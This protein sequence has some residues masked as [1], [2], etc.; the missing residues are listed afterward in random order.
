MGSSGIISLA[1]RNDGGGE[2]EGGEL[3]GLALLTGDEGLDDIDNL[4]LL[5]ARQTADGL[6][7]AA[8][9]SA[10]REPLLGSGLAEQFL[11]GDAEGLGHRGQDIGA[12]RFTRVLPILD[13]GLAVAYLAGQLTLRK[14]GGLTEG[15]ESRRTICHEA[16]VRGEMEN[17]LHVTSLLVIHEQCKSS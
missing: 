13:I 10:R 14:P 6:D 5:A 1:P 17:G 4:V 7:D 11:N 15:A 8:E 2:K 12:R 16:N 9:P 3:R